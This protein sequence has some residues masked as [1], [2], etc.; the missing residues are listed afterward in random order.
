[1]ADS[2]YIYNMYWGFLEFLKTGLSGTLQHI[3]LET[4]VSAVHV[5]LPCSAYL[6]RSK[7]TVMT[8]ELHIPTTTLKSRKFQELQIHFAMGRRWR[9]IP[10]LR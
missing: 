10:L 4:T 6:T 5:A 2:D 3:V 8:T 1:M 9:D 7:F